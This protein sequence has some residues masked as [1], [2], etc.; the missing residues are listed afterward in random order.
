MI[1]QFFSYPLSMPAPH[2]CISQLTYRLAIA[3]SNSKDIDEDISNI[4]ANFQLLV[5]ITQEIRIL[6][7]TVA[8]SNGEEQKTSSN[9]ND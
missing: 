6:I 8:N 9:S 4:F 1:N 3:F 2:K 5:D 7:D